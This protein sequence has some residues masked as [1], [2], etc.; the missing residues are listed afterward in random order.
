MGMVEASAI[1][2]QT[3]IIDN[4]TGFIKAGYAGEDSARVEVP[5]VVGSPSKT[6]KSVIGGGNKNRYYGSEA[7]KN[8]GILDLIYPMKSGELIDRG[9]W[10]EVIHYVLYSE[11]R[12]DPSEFNILLTEAPSN[13]SD[14]RTAMMET[15]FE[16]W[17]ARAG[18]IQV[19]A[20]LALY[21]S[22][23]TTGLVLDC[24]DGV[25]HAVPVYEGFGLRTNVK[26]TDLAGRDVTE[27]LIGALQTYSG[28]DIRAMNDRLELAGRIKEKV[29]Y[30]ALDFETEK[31]DYLNNNTKPTV[32]V[33]GDG[34]EVQIGLPCILAPEILMS[35]K[36][37]GKSSFSHPELL[38]M[39]VES[40][41]PE[42]RM[43]MYEHTIL[44]GGTMLMRQISE[45]IEKEYK[46][47]VPKLARDKIQVV[48]CEDK[49]M[50][51]QGGSIVCQLTSFE[52]LWITSAEWEEEGEKVLVD[53][54]L[55]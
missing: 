8:A 51:F 42:V 41:S 44:T 38:A 34:E 46:E 33:M 3:I 50:V 45:R 4:G 54:K 19:Q 22:G 37:Q 36:D 27:S 24:G 52:S 29:C 17:K 11:L 5:N 28:K 39:A 47:R 30:V 32:Y 7:S 49:Y 23:R 53:K 25:S 35:P 12:V 31:A 43:T 1:A 2:G 55:F 21:A 6:N 15:L 20:V 9:A 18:Q 13:P 48:G 16:E 10:A 14:K 26:D 40:L